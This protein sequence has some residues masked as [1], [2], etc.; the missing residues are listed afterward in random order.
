MSAAR[1]S[2]VMP[3][4]SIPTW[5]RYPLTPTGA[6]ITAAAFAGKPLNHVMPREVLLDLRS[7]REDGMRTTPDRMTAAERLRSAE[8]AVNEL[9]AELA[10]REVVLPSLRIAPVSCV[11]EAPTS[12]VDLGRCTPDT[13]HR[14]AAALRAG[15]R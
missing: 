14:L 2:P 11:R 3:T 12:L 9:R 7:G 4:A 6:A 10:A 15:A 1:F 5:P 13:A 8:K